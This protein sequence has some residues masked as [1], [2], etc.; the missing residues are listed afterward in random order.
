MNSLSLIEKDLPMVIVCVAVA[1]FIAVMWGYSF[2][3]NVVAPVVGALFFIMLVWDLRLV[4]PLLLVLLP[5]GPKFPMSFGNLYLATA[6]MMAVYV[7]WFVRLPVVKRSLSFRYSIISVG[8][9]AFMLVLVVSGLQHVNYLLA[10]RTNLLRL[11]QF[12]LYSGLFMI[13]YDMDLSLKQMRRLLILALVAGVGQGLYGAYQWMKYP[14]FYVAGSF[15]GVHNHFGAYVAFL[16]VLLLGMVFRARRR[17]LVLVSLASIACLVYPLIFS[18]SRTAY[19]ALS[20]SLLVFFFMPIGKRNKIILGTAGASA[21]IVGLAAIPMAVGQ[22]MMDIYLTFTGKQM[23]L[24]F[25]YRMRMWRGALTDFLRSPLLGRGTYYYE[26]RDNFYLKVIGETGLL[27]IVTL[28]AL[29]YLVLREEKKLLRYRTGEDLIDGLTLG[30][31]PAT[32]GF[33]VIFNLAGDIFLIHKLM[34]TFWIML[35]L[36]L[37]YHVIHR[38]QSGDRA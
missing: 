26:L 4:L 15:D 30:L 34:G 33:L 2:E 20:L 19:I 21:V 11:V 13:V 35:A 10:N 12:F 8:L 6:V 32:V 27:G 25:Y 14:G 16:I 38:W 3:V 37:R 31:F 23:A 29:L 1:V 18:F 5:F 24:S 17:S 9:A 36:I 7:A 28:F 22:R